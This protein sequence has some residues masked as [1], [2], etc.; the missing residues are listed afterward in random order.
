M[1]IASTIPVGVV[2]DNSCPKGNASLS[3]TRAVT[4]RRGHPV[5]TSTPERMLGIS[6]SP[7]NQEFIHSLVI[8][9]ML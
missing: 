6:P 8:G 4:A 1:A 7:W 9:F 2:T 3:F 5:A